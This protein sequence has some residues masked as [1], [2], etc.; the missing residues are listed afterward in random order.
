MTV[1]L[2]IHFGLVSSPIL[3]LMYFYYCHYVGS[4]CTYKVTSFLHQY[5][6]MM[7][8]FCVRIEYIPVMDSR[9]YKPVVP[10]VCPIM[11][12]DCTE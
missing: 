6:S 2:R 10:R 1:I 5:D 3:H 4:T 9:Y 7:I 12:V 11:G 8:S